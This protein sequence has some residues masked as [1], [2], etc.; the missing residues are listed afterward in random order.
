MGLFDKKSL[1][2]DDTSMRKKIGNSGKQISKTNFVEH[3]LFGSKRKGIQIGKMF[4]KSGK[5]VGNK[6]PI[7][8]KQDGNMK[9]S[10]ISP[11]LS[12]FDDMMNSVVKKKVK[13]F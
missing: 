8:A 12:G 6:T 4:R 10:G 13:Q 7:S 11:S 5:G 3:K 2:Y 9:S 1:N